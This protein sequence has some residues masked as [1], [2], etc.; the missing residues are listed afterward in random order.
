MKNHRQID[1]E[2]TWRYPIYAIMW[3][4]DIAVAQLPGSGANMKVILLYRDRE[5][6]E[7]YLEQIGNDDGNHGVYQVEDAGAFKA[8]LTSAANGGIEFANF[9][10]VA[11]P[12]AFKITAI[13]DLLCALGR[14]HVL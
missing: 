6:A 2:L 4:D 3:G 5:L 7:L 8:L 10:S 13:D 11:R 14:D 9:D 1:F 12:K